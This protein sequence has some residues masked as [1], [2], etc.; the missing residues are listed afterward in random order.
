ML[1]RRTGLSATAGLSCSR[2]GGM[3]ERRSNLD[4]VIVE[5]WNATT[6]LSEELSG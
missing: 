2:S 3:K 5:F 1:S 6:Q 4:S